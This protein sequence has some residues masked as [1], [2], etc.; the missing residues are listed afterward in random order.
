MIFIV[1]SKQIKS[2]PTYYNWLQILQTNNYNSELITIMNPQSPETIFLYCWKLLHQEVCCLFHE[3]VMCD[4]T[5]VFYDVS[6]VVIV[7]GCEETL[8][9]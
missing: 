6:V 9:N 5:K 4:S 2:L 8:V 7:Y 1:I 3:E